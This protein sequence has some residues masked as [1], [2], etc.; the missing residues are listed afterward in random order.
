MRWKTT[1]TGLLAGLAL[2]LAAC[3]GGGAPP[4]DL[5]LSG[6]SPESPTVVQ[7]GSVALTLAFTSQNGF[8][9]QVALSVTENGQ[10][11][12]WLTLSPTS[13]SLDVPKGGEARETLE[14]R[15]AED[16]PTGSHSLKLWVVYG[17]KTAERD[18]VLTVSAPP[19]FALSDPE[20]NPVPVT[21]GRTAT[22][23]VTLTPQNG[24]QGEVALSLAPGEHGVPP[25]LALLGASPSPV[26][27]SPERPLEVT[28]T[29]GAS[30]PVTPSVYRL[31]L[32]AQ[33]GGVTQERP[34]AVEVRPEPS[35]NLFLSSSALA[36]EQGKG[37]SV[38]LTVSPLG[39]FTG[40]V[41]LSLAAGEDP[42]PQGLNLS[43]QS[44]QVAGPSPVTQ[45]LTLTA[46][47]TTPTGTYRI[48]VR[49][50]SGSL[51]READLAVTVS[52]PPPSPDFAL[53]LS[54]SELSVDQG[55]YGQV[56]LTL[57]PQNG[58]VGVVDLSLV[59][60]VGNPPAGIVVL[61]PTRVTVGGGDPVEVSF[62]FAI[63]RSVPPGT[64]PLK[65]RGTSGSL[66]REA[67]LALTVQAPSSPDFDL[68]LSP[69]ALEVERG[70]SG[71]T[72]LTLT[73]QN[74]FT[75][76]VA[77]SL[78]GA[79]SGVSLS[80]T[81]VQVTGSSPVSQALYCGPKFGPPYRSV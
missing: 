20:P 10:A 9:G 34:L 80:P 81:S 66:V 16:A 53:S 13:K 59:D 28:V 67:D 30:P 32:R 75:G 31:V 22:F 46:S 74:G 61:G 52:A 60:A 54:P 69:Q 43:P 68:A 73:P 1:A 78:V 17:D 4:Q 44:V 47:S 37:A 63:T 50:V 64:Y 41:D 6:V 5:A 23:R 3:N 26:V 42:V 48:K 8:R 25:G 35:F 65:V 27:L 36:V 11:P 18:L 33:G 38:S 49:G 77:L 7:G 56:T 58:F 76:T 19:S 2:F 51:T 15:V 21:L 39:G 79:P 71:R 29:L 40:Q 24:F 70:G 72:V 12:S 45:A 62:S 57:T 55:G 14:V